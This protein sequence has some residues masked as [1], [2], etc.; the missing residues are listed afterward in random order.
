[1][2]DELV[3]VLDPV[4]GKLTGKS[5]LKSVAHSLGIWH[6]AVHV[7]IY[8]SKGEI[9]LQ[10]RSK[11]KNLFP[12]MWDVSVGG[13]VGFGELVE[14][15][16]VREVSEEIGLVVSKKDVEKIFSFKWHVLANDKIINNEF[17]TVFLLKFDGSVKD[18][19]LQKEEVDTVKFFT[20][21]FLEKEIV[22]NENYLIRTH[23]ITNKVFDLIKKRT[24]KKN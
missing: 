3:D 9:L 23:P 22:E 2:A 19:V 12:N 11:Q 18:L 1:M 24:A 20:I 21:P 13:H 8:N 6:P 15:V 4:S 7:W 5:V 16:A 14:D 17:V 10:H